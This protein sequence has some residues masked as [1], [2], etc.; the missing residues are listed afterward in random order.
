MKIFKYILLIVAVTL[1]LFGSFLY[2]SEKTLPTYK[3]KEVIFSSS[4]Q[5]TFDKDTITILTWNIGYCGLGKD[6]DFFYD[7]GTRMRTSKPITLSNLKEI[8]RTLTANNDADCILLQ[9]IDI[10]SKRSYNINQVE[11]MKANMPGYQHYFAANYVADL[12]PAPISSPLGRVNSGILTLT[13]TIP[14]QVARHSYPDRHPWPEG[15]FM[16][17]RCFMESRISTKSGKELIIVNTHNSAYDNG[18][19]RKME[20]DLLR[21]FVLKEYQKGNWIIV[22]GDWNQNPTGYLQK[23]VD[24]EALKHFTPGQIPE[25]YFPKGWHLAWD[26]GTDSNRFLNKPYQQ[27]KT[28]TT[29]IDFFLLSPNIETLSVRVLRDGFT[30][31]D[32]QQVRATFV[33]KQP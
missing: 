16:P 11:E 1:L 5:S 28:M 19:L 12:I 22:G 2:Y 13:Q 20:M 18:S 3:P 4:S 23:N 26:K 17:K 9:E 14:L 6:M 29:T 10:N 24:K 32:H 7:G 8:V 21:G 25:G 15:L 31:S 27:G 30:Y 33:L